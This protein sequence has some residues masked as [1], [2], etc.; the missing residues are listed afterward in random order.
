MWGSKAKVLKDKLTNKTQ[1]RVLVTDNKGLY[2]SIQIEK[3]STRQGVKMQSL[4]YQ[5]LYDLV[6][7]YNFQTYWVNGEH[8]LADGLT[9]LSSSGSNSSGGKVDLIREVLRSSK[10]RITYC[11]T[12]G[13]KEKQGML[14]LDPLRP[15][16][17]DLSSSIDV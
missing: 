5:I 1:R 11:E 13:R 8:Q 16:T 9:K 17:L 2:D 7:D 15:T 12:S 14:K 4:V 3:P 6:V 10:I